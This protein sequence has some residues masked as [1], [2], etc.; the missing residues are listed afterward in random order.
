MSGQMRLR[1][2]GA[3]QRT[4]G[5]SNP[6]RLGGVSYA[7]IGAAMMAG[8]SGSAVAQNPPRAESSFRTSC[9]NLDAERTNRVTTF[10]AQLHIRPDQKDAWE[11]FET[12]IKGATDPM[13]QVCAKVLGERP[14]VRLPDR[15]AVLVDIQS[16]RLEALKRESRAVADLYPK[17]SAE[18]Q[19]MAD[20]L[21]GFG[22]NR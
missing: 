14:P 15:M 22:G 1:L 18:Q 12:D 21:R 20:H 13:K 5:D 17:L 10:G 4:K 7:L 16:A 8:V 2:L 9:Q 11:R 3:R 19:H 6:L